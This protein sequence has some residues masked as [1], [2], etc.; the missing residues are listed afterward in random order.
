MADQGVNESA[1]RVSRR[2][3]YNQPCGLVDDDQ[4]SILE[5]DIERDRLRYG[6]RICILGENYDKILAAAD[7]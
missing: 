6:R 2:R 7:P 4:M 1:V 5:A 3:M